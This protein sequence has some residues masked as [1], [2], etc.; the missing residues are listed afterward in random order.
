MKHFNFTLFTHESYKFFFS[1]PYKCYKPNLVI[2]DSPSSFW[3]EDVNKMSTSTT[4]EANPKHDSGDL[5]SICLI[6]Y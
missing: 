6:Y 5:K 4:T 1:F 3:E 2:K